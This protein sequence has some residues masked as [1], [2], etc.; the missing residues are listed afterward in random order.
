MVANG[1]NAANINVVTKGPITAPCALTIR[2]IML[3]IWPQ[4]NA[5]PIESRPYSS[6]EIY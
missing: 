4:T 5:N 2:S 1:T 6:A 3:P